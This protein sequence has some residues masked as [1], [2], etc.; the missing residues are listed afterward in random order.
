MTIY[1]KSDILG[2]LSATEIPQYRL[3]FEV[4]HYEIQLML[5]LGVKVHLFST[6]VPFEV[7]INP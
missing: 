5:D 6:N 1:E 3:P 7:I 2:G 4:V